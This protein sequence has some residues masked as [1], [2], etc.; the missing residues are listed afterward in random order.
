MIDEARHVA[1]GNLYLKAVIDRM[2][3]DEREDCA[4]FAFEAVKGMADSQGC[5]SLGKPLPPFMILQK[6]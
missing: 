4:Q 5:N 6:K 3:P 1:F 2:H